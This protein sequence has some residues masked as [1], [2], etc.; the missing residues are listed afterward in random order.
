MSTT[1]MRE[2]VVIDWHLILT[3][4]LPREMTDSTR[5]A[6]SRMPSEVWWMILDE[7][8]DAPMFFATIYTGNGW[9]H[10]AKACVFDEDEKEY[11][12]KKQQRQII[13]SVCRS[14]RYFAAQR[15]YHAVNLGDVGVGKEAPSKAE[16]R[17]ARRV[18]V[19]ANDETILSSITG[20]HDWEIL[21]IGYTVKPVYRYNLSIGIGFCFPRFRSCFVFALFFDLAIG[22]TCL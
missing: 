10:D 9:L 5:S 11:K 16:L 2:L 14:W 12:K 20:R 21:K 17:A 18:H 8:I 15:Q 1:V 7:A 19:C 22:I 6:L 13:A 3:T 4:S